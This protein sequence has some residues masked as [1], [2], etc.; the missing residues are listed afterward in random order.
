MVHMSKMIQIRNVPDDLHREVK[1]RA[2]R[3]GLSLSDYLLREVERIVA[4]PPLE[5]VL[6][7]FANRTRPELTETPV[8]A[9]RRERESR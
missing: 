3:S 5:E 9:L 7:R 8:E 4:T 2:A 6:G 1:A